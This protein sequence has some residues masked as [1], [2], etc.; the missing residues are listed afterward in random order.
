MAAPSGKAC[1]RT[2]PA[3]GPDQL[4]LRA[5]GR[6]RRHLTSPAASRLS[7]GTCGPIR[8]AIAKRASSR[9]VPATQHVPEDLRIIRRARILVQPR[10]RRHGRHRREGRHSTAPQR[11]P[12]LLRGHRPRWRRRRLRRRAADAA[13]AR[14]S[15]Q[16]ES[17]SRD[18]GARC[19]WRCPTGWPRASKPPRS[20]YP[21][22]ARPARWWHRPQ[23]AIGLSEDSRPADAP[24]NV[25]N[26]VLDY[27]YGPRLPTTTI[28]RRHHQSRAAVSSSHADTSG[29]RST[30]TATRSRGVQ[31]VLHQAPLGT[32]TA[33]TVRA[34]GFYARQD[35]RSRRRLHAVRQDQGRTHPAGIRA[36]LWKSATA[37]R[38]ATTARSGMSPSRRSASACC[39]RKTRID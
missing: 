28:V 35:R 6:H 21:T 38:K 4:P 7:G 13:D 11:A 24:N 3:A 17:P 26:V 23:R 25:M 29:R 32:Y 9:P 37:A 31:S 5:S 8:R 18:T 1:G 33:G 12:L 22:L 20:A 2:S 30:R 19:S 16:S 39:C 14:C 36:D 27:D 10:R 34:T 15:R